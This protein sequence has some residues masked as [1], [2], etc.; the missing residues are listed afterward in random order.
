M[1]MKFPIISLTTALIASLSFLP[2]T[3]AENVSFFTGGGYTVKIV[4]F[5]SSASYTG[6][7]QKNRCLTIAEASHY[8]QGSYVWENADYSY[9]M[10][11]LGNN[12]KYR[13]RIFDPHGK[14][15]LNV[16]MDA[17]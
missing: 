16:V 10:S 3:K 13:L 8:S 7:D 14:R 11:P 9:S 1:Q 17:R 12:G 5:G 15:L 6:C 4:G 2:S